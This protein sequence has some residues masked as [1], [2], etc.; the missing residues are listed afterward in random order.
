M[1][2]TL[3]RHIAFGT[4]AGALLTGVAAA[5]RPKEPPVPTPNPESRASVPLP[6][7]SGEIVV[8]ARR[9][10][11]RLLDVPASV[12]V[13][14]EAAIQRAGITNVQQAVNLTPGVSIVTNTAEVGDTQINIRGLNGARDAESNVGL[15]VDGILKTNTSVLNQD[16]GDL[17]QLEILKG[18]QGAIYGRNAEAGAVVIQTRKPGDQFHLNAKGT[19]AEYGTRAGFVSVGGPLSDTLGLLVSGDYRK[20]SG[21][22]RNNGPIAAARG[23]TIDQYEGYNLNARLVSEVSDSLTLDAKARYGHNRSGSINYN[24]VFALPNFAGINPAFYNDVNTQPYQ[25]LSNIPSDGNQTTKETSLKADWDLGRAKLTAWGLYS[26]VKQDLVADA[27]VAAF[28]FF[29]KTP[30]CRASVAALNAAGFKLPAP[31][32]LG[33]V[34]DSSLF[35]SNGSLISSFS[36]TT[37]DGSEYQV[38]NQRDV[39]FE[40]RVASNTSG[41]LSWSFGGYYLNLRRLVGVNLG[42]DRGLGVLR[43]IYA[44]PDTINPTEE[45][46][47]DRFRTNVYA[48]FGSLDYKFSNQFTMSGALRLDR[49]ERRVTNLV[50]PTL[51]NRYV[52]GGNQPLNVGLLNGAL[53]LPKSKAFQQLQPKISFLYKPAP[54]VSLFADW[55]IGFKSGGFNNQGSKAAID[56]QYNQT[57]GSGLNIFDDFKKERSSAYEAGLKARLF[58][59]RLEL[60]GAGYYTNI[61][62]MQFFEFYVGNFGILR[63]VSNIDKVTIYGAELGATLRIMQGLSIYA[64][65]NVNQSKIKKNSARPN[66]EGGKSPYTSDF[67]LNGGADVTVP[68]Q[69]N[70]KFMARADVRVTGPT[71]FSTAQKGTQPTIFSAILPFAG[72]PAF[73]GNSRLDLSRRKTFTIVNLRAGFETPRWRLTAFAN[74]LFAERY[75]AEVIPAPDFGGSFISPGDRRQFGLELGYRF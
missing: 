57:V 73:L 70:L 71:W 14:S 64:A 49:E 45:L 1:A 10:R 30:E 8:T 19:L 3:A 26:D 60:E 27:A 9:G 43:Q 52:L 20:T 47:Y 55:G 67:T 28:G 69:N 11:E 42:Y 21:F 40:V 59:G 68:I 63:V 31:Q 22:Y 58:N 48:G 65:G 44:G 35:V 54:N 18:P 32:I 53:L 37:C 12:S 33:Q 61:K 46:S 66:T 62:D 50:D 56:L 6:S 72:L 36:P 25:F 74:N 38:R 7:E 41:P 24:V 15:V 16:Q 34:P 17:I 29:N 75:L 5:Q 2:W 13:L 51:R 39:S 4:A 23:A